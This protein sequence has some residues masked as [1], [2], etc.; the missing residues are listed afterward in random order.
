MGLFKTLMDSNTNEAPSKTTEIPTVVQFFFKGTAPLHVEHPAFAP[1][2]YTALQTDSEES[3]IVVPDIGV[4]S[5]QCGA[6][7]RVV[8]AL[9]PPTVSVVCFTVDLN[10]IPFDQV[11]PAL[12]A[13]QQTL[14]RH[15]IQHPREESNFP[16]ATT[17]LAALQSAQFGLASEDTSLPMKNEDT[18]SSAQKNCIC[19]QVCAVLPANSEDQQQKIS[20]LTYHLRKFCVAVQASLVL[21]Q[22]AEGGET[23]ALET[24]ATIPMQKVPL[25]WKALAQG[26]PVWQYTSM[27]RLLEA[28][29]GEEVVPVTTTP[30]APSTTEEKESTEDD[31][32]LL[33]GPDTQPELIETIW[34]RNASAPGHW[35]AKKDS[36]WKV[37]PAPPSKGSSSNPIPPGDE[38][39]LAELRA[40]MASTTATT[41]AKT[42]AKATSAATDVTPKDKDVSSFFE[43]LLNK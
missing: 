11:E 28:A 34:L 7:G 42:P 4:W 33:Y 19:L 9:V 26:Q 5:V 37:F 40:S 35:D 16:Q 21:V 20:Y 31:D 1:L 39:W 3:A 8:D 36:I 12:N 13:Q 41:P 18:E 38:S 25:V 24:L 30:E 23:S 27:E 22:A 14:I 15:L 10:T 17:S 6:G 32:V 43:G 29:D 2:H